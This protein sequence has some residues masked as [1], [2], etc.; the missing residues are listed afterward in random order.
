MIFSI[1]C[2]F[3]DLNESDFNSFMTFL[4]CNNIPTPELPKGLPS[5]GMFLIY[6]NQK[7]LYA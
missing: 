3:L 2:I 7:F 5:N 4:K 1:H 6:K